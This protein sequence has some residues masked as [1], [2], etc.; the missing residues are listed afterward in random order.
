MISG[1]CQK[2]S[3]H[4]KWETTFLYLILVLLLYFSIFPISFSFSFLQT[5]YT[6]PTLNIQ[7]ESIELLFR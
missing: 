7:E 4:V 5:T 2:S 3:S 1:F 6:K